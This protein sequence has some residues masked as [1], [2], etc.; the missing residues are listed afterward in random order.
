MRLNLILILAILA[1]IGYALYQLF[2]PGGQLSA[3]NP[4]NQDPT[5]GQYIGAVNAADNWLDPVKF[6]G[7]KG[8]IVGTSQTYTGALGETIS[9]PLNTMESILGIGPNGM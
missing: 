7:Q 3:Q 5:T 4:E 6:P 9:H 2:G 8:E 1:A